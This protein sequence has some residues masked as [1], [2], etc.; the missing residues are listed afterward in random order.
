MVFKCSKKLV[1]ALFT[2]LICAA[3]FSPAVFA[4]SNAEK[5]HTHTFREYVYNKDA[6]C[7]ADGTKTAKCT[8]CGKKK[9]V[10][11][12]NTALGH[13]Y[14][15]SYTVHKK[16]TQSENGVKYRHCKRCGKLNYKKVIS[17]ISSAALC[18]KTLYCTGKAVIPAV[19]VINSAG[20]KLKNGT[21]YTVKVTG[22][23]AKCGIYRLSVQFKGDYKGSKALHFKIAPAAPKIKTDS[24]SG[25]ITLTWNKVKGAEGY[26]VYKYDPAQKKYVKVSSQKGTSYT[27][28]ELI[29]FKKYFFKIR[30][31]A[32]TAKEKTLYSPYCKIND[33]TRPVTPQIKSVITGVKK[34]K[35]GWNKISRADGYQI[36]YSASSAFPSGK[37]TYKTVRSTDTVSKFLLNLTGG[38]K[39]YIKIRSYGVKE[40]KKIYSGFSA[41]KTAVPYKKPG[42]TPVSSATQAAVVFDVRNNETVFS[43]NANQK[44]LPASMTKLVTACTALKYVSPDKVYTVGNEIYLVDPLYSICGLQ[45]GYKMSLYDLLCGMLMPSGC[46]AAYCI[47]AHVGKDVGGSNMSNSEAADYFCSLMNK[48]AK[49]I[50]MTSSHFNSPEGYERWSHYTTPA[51]MAKLVKYALNNKVIAGIVKHNTRNRTIASGQTLHFESTNRLLFPD[52][53]YYNPYVIGMKTGTTTMA[54]YCIS[55]AYDDGLERL[56][57]ISM[58]NETNYDRYTSV[59]NIIDWYVQ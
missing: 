43:K 13:S 8:V 5:K 1:T 10:K 54:G 36:A 46:D 29:S 19:S 24:G 39:Y 21:D 32:V 31:Y 44:M 27:A 6:T 9:T 58:G 15:K 2:V 3:V 7:T 17:R 56:I 51:D 11:A 37:T 16:A 20:G 49:E 50:G 42:G 14:E 52:S 4:K 59:N 18:E 25:S 45:T 55:V 26:L 22:N 12:A 57:V 53:M 33:C 48:F 40:E 34:I 47:A 30:A 38:K 28:K 35:L 23:T 41:V